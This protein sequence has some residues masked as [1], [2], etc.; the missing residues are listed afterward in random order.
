MSVSS[1]LTC[2]YFK[3]YLSLAESRILNSERVAFEKLR[4]AR[5]KRHN[6]L[7]WKNLTTYKV[8][9][10]RSL[11]NLDGSEECNSV[12]RSETDAASLEHGQ[13]SERDCG[14]A[15]T[16]QQPRLVR[17]AGDCAESASAHARQSEP[18]FVEHRE[19]HER[20]VEVA[21]SA[22]QG[23][24]ER[25]GELARFISQRLEVV[26]RLIVLLALL[27]SSPL[28]CTC[29]VP[30]HSVQ[31]VTLETERHVIGPECSTQSGIRHL[32]ESR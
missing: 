9:L 14:R 19:L 28:V 11:L 12:S 20:Q 13:T 18:P 1:L 24:N 15:A 32:L 3:D 16:S 7:Y 21:S 27:C 8:C 25:E 5:S 26:F 31:R 6:V 17:C 2:N 4:N 23:R 22:R 30:T 10:R 29:V